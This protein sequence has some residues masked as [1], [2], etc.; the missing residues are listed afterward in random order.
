MANRVSSGA[1][2][3]V[4]F[5]RMLLMVA[6]RTPKA[7]ARVRITTIPTPPSQ[8][9][10]SGSENP[11]PVKNL[12]NPRDDLL[13]RQRTI[14][15]DQAMSLLITIILKFCDVFCHAIL[16]YLSHASLLSISLLYPA[17]IRDNRQCGAYGFGLVVHKV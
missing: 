12:S 13:F 9:T 16:Q 7:Y 2:P 4:S 5:L 11:R 3:S 6:M 14:A 17:R 15:H 1:L 10:V 8:D